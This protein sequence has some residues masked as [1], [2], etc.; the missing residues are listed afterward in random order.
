M[1]LHAK[2]KIAQFHREHPG[3]A[4]HINAAIFNSILFTRADLAISW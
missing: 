3:A 1:Q 2:S 4:H